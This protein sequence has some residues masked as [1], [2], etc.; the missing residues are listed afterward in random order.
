MGHARVPDALEPTNWEECNATVAALKSSFD[1]GECSCSAACGERGGVES[2]DVGYHVGAAFVV[3]VVAAL[4]ACIPLLLRKSPSRWAHVFVGLGKTMGTGV[5]ISVGLVHMLLPG[6]RAFEN[7]CIPPEFQT[8]EAHAYVF[9]MMAGFFMH[10]FEAVLQSWLGAKAHDH[11]GG[12]WAPRASDKVVDDTDAELRDAGAPS[13]AAGTTRRGERP[14][15]KDDDA[16]LAHDDLVKRTVQSSTMEFAFTVHSV[17]IGLV[18]GLSYPD[19]LTPLLIALAFHQFFEGVALGARLSEARMS[20][21]RVVSFI[22]VFASSAPVGIVIGAGAFAAIN[23]DN[24]AYLV[25][26]GVAD[27]ICAGLLLYIGFQLLLVDFPVDRAA[28]TALFEGRKE[29]VISTVAVFL[30]LWFGAGIM[31]LLGLWL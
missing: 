26:Q 16:H 1:S 21:K 11:G 30:A 24:G 29:R 3:L 18:L 19:Q 23:A 9:F 17:F 8:Y 13:G 10:A 20:T 25:A 12:E 31:A 28:L 15:D 14:F 22:V 27:S 5:V 4:G 2:F 6:T 7:P